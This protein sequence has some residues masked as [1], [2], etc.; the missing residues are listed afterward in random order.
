MQ[1]EFIIVITLL[2]LVI[3]LLVIFRAKPANDA[4][5]F[6]GRIDQ[7]QSGLKEDF[8][9]NRTES[10]V[11]S[12][13][14]RRELNDT[15]KDFK[16]ELTQTLALITQQNQ[17]ALQQVSKTVE[18]NNKANRDSLTANLKDFIAEQRTKF[19]DLKNGQKELAAGTLAQLEK[20]GVQVETKLTTLTE[21]DKSDSQLM[22]IALEN[23][24]KGFQ[25]TFDK[26]VESFNNL[27]K[28]KFSQLDHK[29]TLMMESNERKLEEMRVTVDEKL[30]KT[31]NERLGQSFEM[32]GKQLESVQ[33]GLGEM[34]ALAQDVGGLKKVLSNVKM[35]G[36]IGEVQLAMLLEQVLAPEQYAA[37]V[38]TKHDS[39]DLVEFAIKLPGRD[40]GNSV[41]YL[42][43]DAKF[44]KD[45]YEQLQ[46]AYETAD[47]AG[48]DTASKNMENVIKKMAKDIRDKY[49]DPPNTTDFAIMFLPF[50][51]IY[52]EV[53][54]KASLLDV[55][56]REY[57]VIVTGPTTL[58]AILNSL[59]M[60]F[61]TLALQQ[62]SSEVWKILGAVKTEFTKFGGL[63][64][65]AQ[66]NLH[67]AS[68]QID[69]LLGSR[70]RAINRKLQQVE[71]L[72][73]A[74]SNKYLPEST[75]EE[76]PDN[77]EE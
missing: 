37:N 61:R 48:I 65:K 25:E 5:V 55:L 57:K 18:D 49:I 58:A 21:Q 38:K 36:G 15:L 64:E 34:Q 42:P 77:E 30:Q 63:M 22:R 62:R 46:D 10:A 69:E 66:K 35:R 19:D 43:V 59:Q 13:D 3:I 73:L 53:V 54:R 31:L 24:F 6:T 20:I 72:P 23:A 40:E 4:T 52:A 44:P 2:V 51:G 9:L 32:V 68:S 67:I 29:Q 60:G 70:T 12:K 16:E 47:P 17:Q 7:L 26:N 71:A 11:L 56:Q 39:T 8:L 50:E 33:K 45:I 1:T 74:E 27:Q 76:L 14:N 28:E 75:V 41:V